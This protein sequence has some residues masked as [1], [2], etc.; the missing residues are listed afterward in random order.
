MSGGPIYQRKKDNTN[1][2][3]KEVE[4]E[5]LGLLNVANVGIGHLKG[6]APLP[7]NRCSPEMNCEEMKAIDQ[8][9]KFT[10]SNPLLGFISNIN[11][12]EENSGS[13]EEKK[14]AQQQDGASKESKLSE[15]NT[16]TSDQ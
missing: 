16:P 4:K 11:P 14:D 2:N 7:M 5:N 8:S 6:K 15:Q 12:N 13:V 3:L 9:I 1:P 10:D